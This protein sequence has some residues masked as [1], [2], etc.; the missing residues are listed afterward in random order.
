MGHITAQ[1]ADY[2]SVGGR[3]RRNEGFDSDM[4]TAELGRKES[5][6]NLLQ[7]AQALIEKQYDYAEKRK[8]RP[9]RDAKA[10][11]AETGFGNIQLRYEQDTDQRKVLEATQTVQQALQTNDPALWDQ[12]LESMGNANPAYKQILE[13][14][15]PELRRDKLGELMQQNAT[16]LE[17]QQAGIKQFQMG[18]QQRDTNF[19]Q[20]QVRLAM[21]QN[22]NTSAE[23]MNAARIAS[24]EKLAAQYGPGMPG[25][26]SRIDQY[27]PALARELEQKLVES[28]I[29]KNRVIASATNDI[30]QK[31]AWSKTLKQAMD[32]VRSSI[33]ST[34]SGSSWFG[35]GLERLAK[36]EA[37]DQVPGMGAM[38]T[39]GTQLVEEGGFTANEVHDYLTKRYIMVNKTKGFIP[40]P[41][42]P[43]GS[44]VG[45]A[46]ADM[47]IQKARDDNGMTLEE[48]VDDYAKFLKAQYDYSWTL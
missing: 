16:T 6:A 11:A 18:E 20:A 41:E 37:I 19:E 44:L 12:A 25:L 24:N 42:S 15:P 13:Q 36:D 33:L 5:E 39:R 22:Q 43:N 45:P 48:V 40:M 35:S 21:A 46:T 14:T 27:D 38:K 28:S 8:R 32:S 17:T 47:L 31:E 26:I 30:K 4:A 29:E 2:F 3:R 9:V 23:A 7:K 34:Y 1:E 10:A